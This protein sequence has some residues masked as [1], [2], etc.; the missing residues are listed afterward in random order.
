[1]I[2]SIPMEDQDRQ[3]TVPQSLLH[4]IHGAMGTGRVQ[5]GS[6]SVLPVIQSYIPQALPDFHKTPS[7][8]PLKT[9]SPHLLISSRPSSSSLAVYFS[10]IGFAGAVLRHKLR[11]K[12]NITRGRTRGLAG[13]HIERFP[14][15]LDWTTSVRPLRDRVSPRACPR[16]GVVHQ[17]THIGSPNYIPP[18]WGPSLTAL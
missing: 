6:W 10:F 12:M 3:I 16:L 11:T 2:A 4:P 14:T 13:N 8:I 9:P 1:M 18:P 7:I 15:N 17:L 5:S